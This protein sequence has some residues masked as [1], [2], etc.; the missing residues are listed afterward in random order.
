MT[1]KENE[2]ISCNFDK[3]FCGYSEET[4]KRKTGEASYAGPPGDKTTGDGYYALCEG[5]DLTS[6]D[7]FCKLS[8]SVTVSD[9]D[10]KL[11]FWYYMYGFEIG[12][13]K[14]NGSEELWSKSGRQKKEWLKAVVA[15][16]IGNYTVIVLQILKQMVKETSKK[17]NL[18]QISFLATKAKDSEDPDNIAIDDISLS[19]QECE[20]FFL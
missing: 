11:S 2:Q 18:K 4:F 9:E 10:T 15:L 14:L 8:Q 20:Y 3:D 16:P 7:R 1:K 5:D 6:I 19:G 13:L 12:T 17:I